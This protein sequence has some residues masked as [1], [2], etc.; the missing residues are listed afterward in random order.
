ML[1]NVECGGVGSDSLAHPLYNSNNLTNSYGPKAKC[2]T[3]H[4]DTKA[5]NNYGLFVMA[6]NPAPHHPSL[7]PTKPISTW[8]ILII[9]GLVS[10]TSIGFVVGVA[11]YYAYQG[12]VLPT[13]A[14]EK[15]IVVTASDAQQFIANFVVRHDAETLTKTKFPD[16]SI[17]VDYAY[18]HP[19]DDSQLLINCRVTIYK[20]SSEAEQAFDLQSKVTSWTLGEGTLAEQE[21]FKVGDKPFMA[22]VQNKDGVIMGNYVTYIRDNRVFTLQIYGLG[23]EDP[24]AMNQLIAP[25]V[26]AIDAYS[27]E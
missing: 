12:E 22:T 14:A 13:S 19:Q 15:R 26:N 27:T 24:I 17:S 3:Q 25:I 2:G 21:W 18:D 5:L 16:E 7:P 11:A 20:T 8:H 4:T 23:F 9:V 6:D 10:L 1:N